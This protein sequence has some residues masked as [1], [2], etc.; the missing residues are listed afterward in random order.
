MCVC[1]AGEEGE[2]E[3][4]GEE[5]A[6]LLVWDDVDQDELS[7][8]SLVLLDAENNACDRIGTHNVW[9]ESINNTHTHTHTHTHTVY[10]TIIRILA[11]NESIAH[12]HR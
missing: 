3:P 8:D 5:G 2:D 12:Y 11:Y 10:C 4:E 6:T 1:T 7:R 9:A